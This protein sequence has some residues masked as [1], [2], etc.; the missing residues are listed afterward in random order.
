MSDHNWFGGQPYWMAE[1]H[2]VLQNVLQILITD[3]GD[4]FQAYSMLNTFN[5]WNGKVTRQKTSQQWWLSRSLILHM[6]NSSVPFVGSNSSTPVKL[7][8]KCWEVFV[9]VLA[10]CSRYQSKILAVGNL[11]MLHTIPQMP[12]FALISW[13]YGGNGTDRKSVV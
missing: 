11:T 7:C 5:C 6:L 8:S 2:F 10:N 1:Y 3:R 9:R 12:S 4:S 13:L